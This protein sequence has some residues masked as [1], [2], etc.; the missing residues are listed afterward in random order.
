MKL[1]ITREQ[2]LEELER[3]FEDEVLSCPLN[4]EALI[5]VLFYKYSHKTQ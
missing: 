2:L 4:A 3:Y 1:E 5:D